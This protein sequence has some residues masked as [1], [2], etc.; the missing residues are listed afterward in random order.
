MN[1][2]QFYKSLIPL[3]I[4]LFFASVTS[5]LLN[6]YK[7][8][9]SSYWWISIVFYTAIFLVLNIVYNLKHTAE[10]FS[11]LLLAT[12]IIKLLLALVLVLIMR[13]IIKEATFNFS[14]HFLIHYVLFTIFEIH[15]LLKLIKFKT[16]TKQ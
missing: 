3:L 5:Y 13:V 6:N 7:T 8:L 4:A 15:Y 1:T 14:M 12:L 2:S 10:A 16:L 9:V 11:Q